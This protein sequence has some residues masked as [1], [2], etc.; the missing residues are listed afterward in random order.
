MFYNKITEVHITSSKLMEI[1]LLGLG[2]LC[3]ECRQVKEYLYS[4][5]FFPFLMAKQHDLI[6]E[7]ENVYKLFYYCV[8]NFTNGL[9]KLGP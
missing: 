1:C 7:N 9:N 2:N 8:D 3:G 4:V 6:F 5:D